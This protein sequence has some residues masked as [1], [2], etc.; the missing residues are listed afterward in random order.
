MDIERTK[1]NVQK[2]EREA[3]RKRRK[4]RGGKNRKQMERG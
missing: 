2:T 3:G 4:K 1:R